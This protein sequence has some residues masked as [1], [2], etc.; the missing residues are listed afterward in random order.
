MQTFHLN[1]DD[2]ETLHA[3]CWLP[4]GAPRAVVLISHGM[5]EYAVRYHRFAQT[6]TAAGYAVY[7][8][9]HR[10]HG[11]ARAAARL[12]RRR[13]RLGQGG[14]RRGDPAPPRGGTPPQPA[15]GPVR[16]QHG[17]LHRPRFISCATARRC[18]DSRCPPPAT[19]SGRWPGCCAA[20][21]GW[22][23]AAA[24]RNGLAGCWRG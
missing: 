15:S 17:L 4:D 20:W 5:S 11:A 14:G 19:A 18:P 7:A 3:A 13:E 1:A 10:G 6:L 22:W 9:D 8:H 2:G 21:R 23:P 12:F 16:P 24:A